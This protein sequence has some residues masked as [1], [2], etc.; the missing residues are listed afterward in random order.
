MTEVY[1]QRNKFIRLG[2][3]E[4]QPSFI[5]PRRLSFCN[6]SYMEV[7]NW[8]TEKSTHKRTHLSEE[9][10]LETLHSLDIY[11]DTFEKFP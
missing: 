10:L 4:L 7:L 2:T 9:M 5:L 3:L 1:I 11:I 6:Q 8:F